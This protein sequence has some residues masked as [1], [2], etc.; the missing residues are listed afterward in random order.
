MAVAME[1][2]RAKRFFEKFELAA[3]TALEA[4]MKSSGKVSNSGEDGW[5]DGVSRTLPPVLKSGKSSNKLGVLVVV[6]AADFPGAIPGAISGAIDEIQ[7][8]E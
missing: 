2:R 1:C 5:L 4:A 6:K 7:F 8:K 3:V